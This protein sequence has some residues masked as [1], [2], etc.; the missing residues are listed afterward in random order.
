MNSCTVRLVPPENEPEDH[1][2]TED[3]RRERKAEER[4]RHDELGIE[5]WSN[6][7]ISMARAGL[8]LA[9]AWDAANLDELEVEGEEDL[10]WMLPTEPEHKHVGD[11]VL[12]VFG[13][14]GELLLT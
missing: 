10:P 7:V 8:R 13:P 3:E 1:D 9:D 12:R 4:R 5:R 6:S 14:D 2:E 11:V